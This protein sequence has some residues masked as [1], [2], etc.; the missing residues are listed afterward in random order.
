MYHSRESRKFGILCI[1]FRGIYCSFCQKFGGTEVKILEEFRTDIVPLTLSID[2][3]RL[4][5]QGPNLQRS[6][7][8]NRLL[9]HENGIKYFKKLQFI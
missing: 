3:S 1:E 4:L 8:W 6:V 2:F 9:L 5:V 7:D